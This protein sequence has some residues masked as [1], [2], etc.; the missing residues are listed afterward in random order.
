MKHDHLRIEVNGSEVEE[1][2]AD[3][4]SL[5][6]ELDS[7]LA[8]MFRIDLA[9]LLGT[10]GTWPYL[11]D[12]R[13]ALWHRVVVTAGLEDDPTQLISGYITHLRP[14]L[15]S[16]LDQCRLE[17]WGMDASVLMDR[18]DR[19]KDWPNK[20]DSDIAAEVFET[21]GL[22]PEVTHTEV[23]HDE[24]VSTIVQRETDIQLLRRLAL[25]NGFECFVDG[26]RG[27]FRPPPTD[28]RTQPVLA[29]HFGDETNLDHLRLQANALTPVDVVM[30]QLDHMSGEV[31]QAG[32][33][34]GRRPVLGAEPAASLKVPQDEVG[35]LCVSRAVTTGA[36][37]M[38]A[39]C[40]GLHDRG[41]WFVTAE[42]DVAANEYGTVLMPRAT[43]LIKGAGEAY[44]GAY[45]VTHVTH[46]FTADGYTQGFRAQRNALRPKGDEDFSGED[47]GL[48]AALTGGI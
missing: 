24:L 11:D 25:R 16:R 23:V 20:K 17:I 43:V 9:L 13:F 26:D 27:C 46:R 42:G 22:T 14:H 28:G 32:S 8:G 29:V 4:V 38:S 48:L 47:D 2:Y 18:V 21:Y 6:V 35:L 45:Y 5:E 33:E 34:S 3:L 10:D 12:E 7:E 41:E 37:E 44:S 1:L 31:L 36:E 30:T 39:L 40:Q 19:L 15:G